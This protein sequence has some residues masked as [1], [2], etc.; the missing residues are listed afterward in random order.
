[1][2]SAAIGLSC[3][4]MALRVTAAK[5]ADRAPLEVLI[6]KGERLLGEISLHADTDVAVFEAYMAALRLPKATEAEK[7][8]RREALA[9]AA[10]AA[11]EAPLNAAQATLEGLDLAR[12]AAPVAA[13]AIA[14]DVGAGAAILH[15]ALRAVLL[16]V[17]VNL[18][19]IADRGL[20]GE[21]RASRQHLAR[22][23]DDRAAAVA[24]TVAARLAG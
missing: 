15:G 4:L 10:E 18:G 3:V 20:A 9:R 23:A 16:A 14:S 7:A 11:T 1:M 6:L 2:V 5:A 12:A 17:D 22:A 19:A 24:A 8:I 13:R 21:Y